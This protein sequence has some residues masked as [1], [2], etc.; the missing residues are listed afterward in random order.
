MC[1]FS[2]NVGLAVLGDNP[3]Q[4]MLPYFVLCSMLHWIQNVG[5]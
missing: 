4:K 2:F 3:W 1:V 5:K